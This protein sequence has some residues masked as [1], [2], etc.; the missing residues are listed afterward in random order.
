MAAGEH[1]ASAIANGPLEG[2]LGASWLLSWRGRP[3]RAWR[4]GLRRTAPPRLSP[5]SNCG[6]ATQ[7]VHLR[8]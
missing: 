4:R 2:H 3:G 6:P 8:S 5:S 1:A 7:Y